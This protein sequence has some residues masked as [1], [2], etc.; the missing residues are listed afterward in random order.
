MK[1]HF[2]VQNTNVLHHS[3]RNTTDNKKIPPFLGFVF[4]QNWLPRRVMSASRVA[5]IL[6][7]LEN[8]NVNECGNM[9]FNI[10]KVWQASIHHG[11]RPLAVTSK[12]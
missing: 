6:H 2:F 7:V 11:F 5:G 10:E 4:C 12:A 8:W 3:D 1:A 9:I